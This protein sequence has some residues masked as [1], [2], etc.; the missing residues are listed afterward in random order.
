MEP[1]IEVQELTKRFGEFT[2]VD[3][4]SFTVQP[5]EIVGYLGPNGS[6]KTTTIRMLLGI[7][8]P[9]SGMGR[10]LGHDILTQAEAIRPQVGYTSQKFALYDELTMAENLTFYA[11]VYGVDDPERRVAEVLELLGLAGRERERA[12]ELSGGWRQRLALGVALTHQPRLLFLDEPT[13]GVD[14]QARRAFW[15]LIYDLAKAGTTIFVTTHYM[16]EA[17]YCGRLGIMYQGQLLAIDTP[18][19]LKQQMLN[20]AIWEVEVTPLMAALTA[21]TGAADVLRVGLFGD[22][23]RIV[24]RAQTHTAVSLQSVLQGLGFAETAVTPA[25]PTLEDVFVTLAGR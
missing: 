6:G 2:A 20:G 16:D 21:L 23:L 9:T 25:E 19:N 13:S 10:V 7:L 11:G 12:G 4:V 3:R 15:D 22:R 1:A 8:R 24:T 17:E 18:D 5:G 14:P